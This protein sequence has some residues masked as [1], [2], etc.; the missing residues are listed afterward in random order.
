MIGHGRLIIFKDDDG[1]G[2]RALLYHRRRPCAN[3]GSG[4]KMNN[5]KA[6]GVKTKS[7]QTD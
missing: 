7:W 2:L 5:T 3:P 6:T 4:I 1:P